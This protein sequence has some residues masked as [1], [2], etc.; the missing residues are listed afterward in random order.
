MFSLEACDDCENVCELAGGRRADRYVVRHQ[1]V[2][3]FRAVERF[4]SNGEGVLLAA[5]LRRLPGLL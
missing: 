4:P 2:L 5:L 1:D 3:L